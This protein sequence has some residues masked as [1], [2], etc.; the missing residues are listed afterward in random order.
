MNKGNHDFITKQDLVKMNVIDSKANVL[1]ISEAN[2]SPDDIA[3]KTRGLQLC[4][5]FHFTTQ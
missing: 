2:T 3:N 5:G 1:F 4:P